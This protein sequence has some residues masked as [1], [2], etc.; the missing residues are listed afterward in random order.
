MNKF[1]RGKSILIVLTMTMV[2]GLAGCKNNQASKTP[3]VNENTAVTETET[4][5]N[6]ET[7]TKDEELDS[8]VSS[9]D[10]SDTLSEKEEKERDKN[11]T[12]ADEDTVGGEGEKAE[13]EKQEGKQEEKQEEKQEAKPS[14]GTSSGSSTGSKPGTGTNTASGSTG[15]GNGNGSSGNSGSNGNAGGSTTSTPD[16]TPTSTPQ[17]QVCQ[18]TS[19][20]ERIVGNTGRPIGN[21]QGCGQHGDLY[22]TFCKDCGADL[23]NERTVWGAIDHAEHNSVVID[24]Y[25]VCG[26]TGVIHYHHWCECGEINYDDPPITVQNEHGMRVV[27]YYDADGNIWETNRCAYCGWEDGSDHMVQ[28]AS[29]D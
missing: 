14:N 8:T 17:P 23:G 28:A 15:N 11:E 6:T 2:L 19:T 13:E 16:P 5:V 29:G 26:G 27:Q 12:I 9:D 3:E 1:F 22:H 24:D 10:N 25:G 21:G 7:E 18:H 20:E 4:S